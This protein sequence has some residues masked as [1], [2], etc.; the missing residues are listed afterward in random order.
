MSNNVIDIKEFNKELE[1]RINDIIKT[2]TYSQLSNYIEMLPRSFAS[3][4]DLYYWGF[5]YLNEYYKLMGKLDDLQGEKADI[6][7]H[8]IYVLYLKEKYEH[9]TFS[10]EEFVT[11]SKLLNTTFTD[12][13]PKKIRNKKPFDCGD[14]EINNIINII[15]H[16]HYHSEHP[17]AYEIAKFKMDILRKT[18]IKKRNLL[19]NKELGIIDLDSDEIS[20]VLSDVRIKDLKKKI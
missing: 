10:Y 5:S 19:L 7:K 9:I 4:E 16:K 18:L 6:L 8:K 1:E 15:S 20:S 11:F 2:S 12:Y 14:E 17:H 13:N 3:E